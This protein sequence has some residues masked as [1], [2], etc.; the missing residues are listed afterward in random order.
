MRSSGN[1]WLG[2]RWLE[3]R[4]GSPSGIPDDV[5]HRIQVA[6]L[7]SWVKVSSSTVPVGM[8]VAFLLGLV[9]V[10]RFDHLWLPAGFAGIAAGYL[11]LFDFCRSWRKGA[12]G[13]VEDA[14]RRLLLTRFVLACF[15]GIALVGMMSVSDPHEQILVVALAVALIS[16]AA[17]GGPSVYALSFWLPVTLG[18]FGT[19]FATGRLLDLPILICMS[20]YALLTFLAILAFDRQNVERN[21]NMLR[22]EQ[23]AETIGILLREFEENSCDWLWE[24]GPD[25]TVRNVSTRFAQVAMR[26][27]AAMEI[28]L[29]SLLTGWHDPARPQG[30]RAIAQLQQRL[31]ART[32]FRELVVPVMIAGEPRW[33]ALSGKPVINSR[34]EFTG[35]RGV[36]AD[37]TAAQLS[38]ERI[39]YLARHDTLT[40]LANRTCFNEALQASLTACGHQG[41][42]LLCIDLDEFKTVNDSYGHTIGD[43]VLRAV[44]LRIRGVLREHDLAARLGG[45]E[46]AILLAVSGRDE[47]ARVADRIIECIRP[48]F[49]CG[50]LVIKIG[51]SVGIAVGPEDGETPEKLYQHADLA[52]YRAKAE[53]RGV[54]R[55]YDAQMDRHLLDQRLLQRDIRDALARGEF[56]V[57]YQPIVDLATRRITSLEALARWRHPVRGEISPGDFIPLAE[58]SGLIGP[59]GAAVL[60]AAAAVAARL[61][62]DIRIAVNLS[63]LQLHD[64]LLLGQV[65]DTLG[66]FGLPRHRIEFEITESVLLETSGRPL[67]TLDAL[68]AQ[69]HPIAIDDFGTGY[70][71][72]AVLNR[73][74]FDRMKIDR[75]F[76]AAMDGAAH[77]G[78]IVKAI[79][80]LGRDLGIPVT[81]EGVE[82]KH[83]ADILRQYKCASAQGYYF[84]RPMSA[85]AILQM[86]ATAPT[87]PA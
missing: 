83:Q 3:K 72:L 11:A 20:L 41:I 1:G 26:P 45:D 4:L 70:S 86:L 23:H 31:T 18:G 60:A 53:G 14:M 24:T 73:F 22:L 7:G 44:A 33:W 71:S 6:Q 13:D 25:L 12:Y 75:S 37:V 17:F 67:E 40:D 42:A 21:L 29:M 65:A 8:T 34:G 81:A 76:I 77:N 2:R 84:H 27:A 5:A 56:Y 46:F 51:V 55:F 57:A 9:Y 62:P 66:R 35:F 58:R 19:L 30:D 78:P 50:D 68:R 47:A 61:P 79:I 48:A 59:I 43:T 80:G 38:D 36:G 39:V 32:P 15:W 52:L 16:T 54:A 49:S 10:G 74:S 64:E 69:G 82:T 85:E 63:P 28:D 87:V